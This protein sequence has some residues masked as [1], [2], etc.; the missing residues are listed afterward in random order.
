MNPRN[1]SK[2]SLKS[3]M[4]A[5]K[6]YFIKPW[7]STAMLT[8]DPIPRFAW[9]HLVRVYAT[10]YYAFVFALFGAFSHVHF[11]NGGWI[12]A[13]GFV[14]ALLWMS[15]IKPW[16]ELFDFKI[17]RTILLMVAAFFSGVTLGPMINLFIEMDQSDLIKIIMGGI[18]SFNCH[19]GAVIHGVDREI[20]Y[21]I[22]EFTAPIFIT[23]WMI[24][25]ESYSSLL[26][27]V[28]FLLVLP[29]QW[30]LAVFF[31][32]FFEYR[33]LIWFTVPFHLVWISLLCYFFDYPLSDL[34]YVYVLVWSLIVH[35]KMHS[36]Q[37]VFLAAHH[38]EESYHVNSTI[39]FFT[40]FPARTIAFFTHH[41]TN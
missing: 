41:G 13:V 21:L 31:L 16:R 6:N 3:A 37:A 35:T 27:H 7:N 40:D 26:V 14:G 11:D 2:F 23:I 4:D 18:V 20:I 29:F 22:G 30:Y 36:Q 9:E 28:I 25:S 15:R 24:I 34:V 32:N 17:P 1:T 12:T 5:I 33:L 10:L 38:N 39:A 8:N 19:L